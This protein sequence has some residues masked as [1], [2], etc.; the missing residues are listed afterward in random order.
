[1]VSGLNTTMKALDVA[2]LAKEWEIMKIL[3]DKELTFVRIE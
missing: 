1:M 2:C 3:E